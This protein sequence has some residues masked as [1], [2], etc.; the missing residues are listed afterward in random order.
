MLKWIRRY[1]VWLCVAVAVAGCGILSLGLSRQMH[2]DDVMQNGAMAVA[3]IN[4]A[5]SISR[6]SLKTYTVDLTWKDENGKARKATGIP[7]SSAFAARII[8]NGVLLIPAT[9]IL[10]LTETPA[11]LPVIVA[12]AAPLS[13]AATTMQLWGGT[14]S[15]LGILGGFLLGWL[16][17]RMGVQ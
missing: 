2:I 11:T 3:I 17:P 15:V 5:Q 10:Y 7:I 16:L 13:T 4:R 14:L 6:K 9:E 8:N 1:F 12:D